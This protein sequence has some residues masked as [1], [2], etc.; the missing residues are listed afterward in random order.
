[1]DGTLIR[2]TD[3]VRY[4][5]TLNGNETTLQEIE[6]QELDGSLTWIEADHRKARLIEGLSLAEAE[7]R[8][9]ETV[10]L[11]QKIE[12][13]IAHLKERRIR[14]LLIT[15][16]PIQVAQ[17]VGRHFAF[18]AVYGSLYE[19]TNGRFTGRITHHLGENGKPQCLEDFCL[20]N[21]I[22]LEHCVAVGDSESDIALFEKCGCSVAINYSDTVRGKA[23]KHII[24]NDLFDIVG[25]I[26][27]WLAQS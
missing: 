25:L 15:A 3:S 19:V 12:Q 23:S 20:K 7:N 11:I 26:E 21:G 9:A 18:D 10:E 14:S 2:N 16:G 24:T 17:I 4:L 27:S 1:M 13:V 22:A 6:K 5:C 8:F